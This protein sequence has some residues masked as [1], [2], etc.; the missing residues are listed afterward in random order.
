MR[1]AQ[2]IVDT[3]LAKAAVRIRPRVDDLDGLADGCRRS[4]AGGRYRS[5]AFGFADSPMA[6]PRDPRAD[7]RTHRASRRCVHGASLVMTAA[8]RRLWSARASISFASLIV[9][10]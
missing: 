7:R 3:R 9:V 5:T 8:E 6:A 2:P 4:P 10:S 1:T